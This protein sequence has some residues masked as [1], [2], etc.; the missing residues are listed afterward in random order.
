MVNFTKKQ[1]KKVFCGIFCKRPRYVTK[2]HWRLLNPN[3]FV[4]YV[5]KLSLQA[6]RWLLPNW[7][8][9]LF[10]Y[11]N[12]NL[13]L[14]MGYFMFDR[15]MLENVRNNMLINTSA[16][17]HAH[18]KTFCG[19]DVHVKLVVW[20]FALSDIGTCS[21]CEFLWSLIA[22]Y[23]YNIAVNNVDYGNEKE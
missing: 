1:C 11:Q 23:G 18:N 7:T 17:P 2:I 14:W 12:I 21:W 8:K 10:I 15:N 16:C 6:D 9:H 20:A 3:Q 13:E 5:E 19:V 22:Y 4:M